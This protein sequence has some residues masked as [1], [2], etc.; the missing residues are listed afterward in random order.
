MR[1]MELWAKEVT[2]GDTLNHEARQQFI[3]GINYLI[4]MAL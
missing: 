2:S 4:L 1:K 3:I